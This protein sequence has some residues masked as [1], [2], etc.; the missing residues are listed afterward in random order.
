MEIGAENHA[1]SAE[2]YEVATWYKS[3]KNY[4]EN[5]TFTINKWHKPD[6]TAHGI[7]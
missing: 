6:G 7:E 5:R 1:I 4:A 2:N 3:L